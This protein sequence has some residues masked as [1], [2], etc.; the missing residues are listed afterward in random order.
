MMTLA[1]ND[2]PRMNYKALRYFLAAMGSLWLLALILL[3]SG[4]PPIYALTL[5]YAGALIGIGVGF[6]LALPDRRRYHGRRIIMLLVGGALLLTALVSNHGNMQIEGLFFALLA[7]IAPYIVLH[8]ALAK[9]IGPVIFGRVWCGWA[10]WFGMVFDLLPYPYSRYRLAGQWGKLRYIHFG[11]SLVIVAGLA[12]GVGY[13]GGA[14]GVSGLTWFISGLVFYY[15]LGIGLALILKDNRAFCKYLC[16]IAV[17]LKLSS[18]YALLRV[19][20]TADKCGKC[21]A[22]V[23]LCPMNIRVKDY[24]MQGKRVT[25]TECTLCQTC[26]NVCPHNSLGLSFKPEIGGEEILDFVAPR[27]R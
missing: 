23:E 6:Y 12:L 3:L 5:A 8:Y 16:P 4:T 15:A 18:R 9:L 17:P 19:A 24:I 10:C 25:S 13:G 11:L 14:L 21:E 27:Q 2:T 20:G 26:I 22:C 1:H 7:G